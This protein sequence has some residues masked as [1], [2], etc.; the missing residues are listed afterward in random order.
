MCLRLPR[1]AQRPITSSGCAS[2]IRQL[3]QWCANSGCEHFYGN[4]NGSS[5]CRQRRGPDDLPIPAGAATLGANTF[6]GTQNAPAFAGDGS[7]L[8]AVAKLSANTF[9]ATQTIDTG[10]LDLD[11][12][13]ATT[14]NLT[15]NGV[16]FLH[17]IGNGNTFLGL[18]AGNFGTTGILNSGIG[19]SALAANTSGSG[20]TANGAVAL[21]NNTSGGS[22]TAIGYNALASN[23]SGF[24]NT[25]VGV[26]A[27]SNSTTGSNNIYLGAGVGGTAGE[28]N[29]L[30]LGNRGFQNRTFIAGVR[31]ITSATADAIPVVID[32]NG[33]LGT[34]SPTGIATLGANTYTGTQTAPQFSGSFVGN[35]AGLTNLLFPSGAATLGANTFTGT[36][37]IQ[38]GTCPRCFD[39]H[40]RKHLE[41]RHAIC[42]HIWH[43]QHILGSERWEPHDDGFG[44]N[45]GIGTAAL[46]NVTERHFTLLAVPSHS[47][48]TRQAKPT[49]LSVPE[50]SVKHDWASNTASGSSAPRGNGTGNQNTAS[51]DSALF[52]NQGSSN[53]AIGFSAMVAQGLADG[54]PR[55]R[56][57]RAL[58]HQTG[59]TNTAVGTTP[60][61]RD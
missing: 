53:T 13:T 36:Q 51:G 27:G 2:F 49:P 11:A 38:P 23:S 21:T 42:S 14:G 6:S 52:H 10:N 8:T 3:P 58:Q 33:Q 24:N 30:Y 56:A 48:I 26:A 50:R 46:S 16:R 15:K 4:A 25:A 1:R 43:E 47:E 28:S 55:R 54:T 22:N 5:L 19:D 57:S 29:T 20:N 41:E 39:R 40:E 17:N 44:F 18:Q 35:G 37:T 34:V 9:V 12:S 61:E 7:A 59:T 31:G 32:S 45:T 60:V